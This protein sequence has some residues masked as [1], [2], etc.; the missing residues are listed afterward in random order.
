MARRPIRDDDGIN[1]DPLE[2]DLERFGTDT[3]PCPFC[4][5][6]VYDEAEWCHKCGKVLGGGDQPASTNLLPAMIVTILV[7]A[8][9]VGFFL[10]R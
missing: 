9:L 5:A 8:M 3:I 10:F 1:D 7:L 6:R 4:G 2:A